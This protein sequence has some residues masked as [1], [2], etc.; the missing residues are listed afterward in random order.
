[1]MKDVT[2]LTFDEM[3]RI[4]QDLESMINLA[5]YGAQGDYKAIDACCLLEANL[6][7]LRLKFQ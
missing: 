3:E 7:E 5:K 1:M 4:R 6:N 2:I